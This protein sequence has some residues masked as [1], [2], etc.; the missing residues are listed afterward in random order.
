MQPGARLCL[1]SRRGSGLET[2]CWG[3]VSLRPAVNPGGKAT[4]TL[5]SYFKGLGLPNVYT[6]SLPD[7]K[8]R[9]SPGNSLRNPPVQA[10]NNL[11]CQGPQA[12][13][14]R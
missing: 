4:P 9:S 6:G 7:S 1:V 11:H 12:S 8:P 10:K 13:T 5:C 2:G 14:Q 3:D